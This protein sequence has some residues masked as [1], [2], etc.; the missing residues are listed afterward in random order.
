MGPVTA[1]AWCNECFDADAALRA[2]VVRSLPRHLLGTRAR[3]L[4]ALL[5][6]RVYRGDAETQAFEV[7]PNYLST[8]RKTAREQGWIGLVKVQGRPVKLTPRS[9]SRCGGGRSRA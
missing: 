7:H 4:S 9:G 2:D 8:L 6:S 5:R 3:A 1:Y